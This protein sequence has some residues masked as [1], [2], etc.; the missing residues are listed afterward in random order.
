MATLDVYGIA[1]MWVMSHG[2]QL[3]LGIKNIIHVLQIMES[4]TN[5]Y[6]QF[7]RVKV[8]PYRPRLEMILP[9]LRGYNFEI[10]KC[11]FKKMKYW[12]HDRSKHEYFQNNDKNLLDRL[13]R[14]NWHA[15]KVDCCSKFM[16]VEYAIIVR[17]VFGTSWLPW[18][19]THILAI[20][21]TS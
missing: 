9:I 14:L 19:M 20:P 16:L 5:F 21:Y 13:F 4:T 10:L 2:N 17:K 15:N 8:W 12:H 7:I 18:D 6:E 11:N 3:Y 1:K